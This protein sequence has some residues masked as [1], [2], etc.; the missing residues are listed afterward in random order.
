MGSVQS[1]LGYSVVFDVVK[2]DKRVKPNISEIDQP[3]ANKTL[4]Y[5]Y[6]KKH[7]ALF[8]GFLPR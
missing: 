5:T 2:T 8:W 7:K 3:N 6:F 4:P 1:V